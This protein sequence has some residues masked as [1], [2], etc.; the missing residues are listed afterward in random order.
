MLSNFFVASKS[1]E[2][3]PILGNGIG[4]HLLSRE[5][6]LKNITGIEIFEEMGND[7]LNA[8]DAGS[9]FSRTMSELGLVGILGLFYF[10]LNF[11]V[12]NKDNLFFQNSTIAKGILLYFI[13]KL[14]REGHYFSPEMY[15]F[16]FLYIFNKY[17]STKNMEIMNLKRI[18]Q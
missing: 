17:E 9:L 18:S 6:Y 4:S 5:I 11:Y 8:Q 10:I 16:V 3:N 1:F 14:L 2:T 7:D 13:L 15:F 12:F